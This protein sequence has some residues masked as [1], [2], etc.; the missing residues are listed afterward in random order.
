M[1]RLAPLLALALVVPAT[2]QRVTA[3]DLAKAGGKS[4]LKSLM[5]NELSDP[6][7]QTALGITEV[8]RSLQAV[9]MA[10]EITRYGY[11]MARMTYEEDDKGNA[12]PFQMTDCF[13]G[14]ALFHYLNDAQVAKLRRMALKD[15]P[16][17][18]LGTPEVAFALELTAAQRKSV[19][20]LRLRYAKAQADPSRPSVAVVNKALAKIQADVEKVQP[21][22]ANESNEDSLKR[23]DLA[24]RTMLGLL[25]AVEASTR[26]AAKEKT[27]KAPDALALLTDKQR[28][29]FRELSGT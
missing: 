19:E 16:L 3:L 11:G 7:A 27:L 26:L 13:P 14:P 22:E 5:T 9:R 18:A 17:S 24:Q 23:I 6:K 1:R 2:A 25:R 10:E 12:A 15:D 29:R 20:G 8:Q 28:R 21:A 4:T